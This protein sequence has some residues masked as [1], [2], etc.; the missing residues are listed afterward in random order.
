VKARPLLG[1]SAGDL[2]LFYVTL[3]ARGEGHPAWVCDGWGAY[4]VGVFRLARDPV[5]GEAFDDLPAEERRGF[6]TN[7]HC[8]REEMDAAVLLRGDP[9]ASGLL[10]P[11]LPLSGE[12]GTDPGPPVERST[13][14]GRGPWWR[15]PLRFDEAA[16]ER[17][18]ERIGH[19][20][21][22]SPDL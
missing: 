5:P 8:R 15:R 11:V 19:R 14:S 9:D 7:A 6:R 4:V 21:P 18:R 20:L 13:D 10:D 2:A 12:R 17:L 22:G 3:D 16:T 1:L